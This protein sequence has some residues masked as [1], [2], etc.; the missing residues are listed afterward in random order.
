MALEIRPCTPDDIVAVEKLH[1]VSLPVHYPSQ[2][3]KSLPHSYVSYVAVLHS[4]VVASFVCELRSDHPSMSNLPSPYCP[5]YRYSVLSQQFWATCMRKLFGNRRKLLYVM[6]LVVSKHYQRQGIA[7]AMMN[8]ILELCPSLGSEGVFLHSALENYKARMFY[9]KA[10]FQ[11]VTILR[12]FYSK[13]RTTL[14]NRDAILWLK[15]N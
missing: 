4:K 1:N 13:S 3:F 10:G 14:R 9:Q 15:L 6:T 2:F 5:L 12:N 7:S 11:E 8:R